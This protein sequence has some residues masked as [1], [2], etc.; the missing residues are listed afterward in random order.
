MPPKHGLPTD[1]D[2][3]MLTPPSSPRPQRPRHTLHGRLPPHPLRGVVFDLDG[4]ITD[5]AHFH[6][7]AWQRLAQSLGLPFD[8]AFNET[9]KGIDRMGSLD[10]ILAQGTATYTPQ[11]KLALARQKNEQYVELISTM[12]SSQLLPG[13]LPLLCELRSK[14]I[15][16]GL[17]SVSRNA[18]LVLNRLGIAHLF[19]HVV[20]VASIERPKPDPEIFATAAA[21]LGLDVTS[22]IGIED[23]VAGV[24][25]IKGAGMYAVGVGDPAVLHE[26]D[27][28]IPGL[29]H[30][31]LQRYL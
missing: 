17:A 21:R 12:D 4:V 22:C 16:T 8:H 18:P 2:A 26:A 31:H 11:E 20:D 19:D 27:E 7:L 28:V 13:A 24:T 14:G 5:T 15:R 10:R 3:D 9:L 6:F 30:F 23:A 29:D 1:G 25:S